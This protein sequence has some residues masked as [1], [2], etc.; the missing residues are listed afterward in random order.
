MIR[1]LFFTFLLGTVLLAA[2]GGGSAIGPTARVVGESVDV[3][4][5]RYTNVSVSQLQAMLKNKDFV[6]VNVHI[7]YEN[8]IPGTD[9]SI[10]FNQVAENLDKLPADKDAKIVVYCR[11]GSMSSIAARTLVRLGYA[12]VWNL[13]G[14][15]NAWRA[16]GLL[17][18]MR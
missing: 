5:G 1:T 3:D 12:N 9:L 17:M 16:A 10:P 8:D 15:F 13:D 18:E 2:C 7:P 6:L 4:G 11:S 14:G